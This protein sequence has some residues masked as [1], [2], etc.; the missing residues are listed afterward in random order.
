[1]QIGG[2]DEIME[3]SAGAKE[4]TFRV[5]LKKS[6]TELSPLFIGGGKEATPYYV[7]VTHQPKPGW[8]TPKGMGMPI[9]D[10]GYGRIPPQRLDQDDP[11]RKWE[12][13]KK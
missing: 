2:I 12:P 8:Q 7:Y 6:V 9:Y 3:I 1:M 10:P 5:N 11:K 13:K 4:V